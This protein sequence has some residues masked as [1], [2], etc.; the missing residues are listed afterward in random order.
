MIN[1][2][3]TDLKNPASLSGVSEL[4]KALPDKSINE[5]KDYLSS[6]NVYTLHKKQAKKFKRR[7]FIC[8]RPGAIITADVAYMHHYEKQNEGFKYLVVFI[9]MFSRYTH[10]VPCE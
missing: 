3:Y 7:K 10:V 1:E 9:D 8:S 5:I 6:N 4:K 2:I